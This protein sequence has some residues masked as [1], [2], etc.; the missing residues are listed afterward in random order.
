MGC[1]RCSRS[2]NITRLHDLATRRVLREFRHPGELVSWARLSRDGQRLVTIGQ[3]GSASCLEH[4]RGTS[5]SHQC[6][7]RRAAGISRHG[8]VQSPMAAWCSPREGNE[9]AR[10]WAAD[11]G[12]VLADLLGHSGPVT[13][14]DFHPDGHQVA[15][16]SRDNTLRISGDSSRGI[17]QGSSWPR[18]REVIE[19]QS[20][21]SLDCCLG[22][23]R[24]NRLECPKPGNCSTLFP[25]RPRSFARGSAPMANAWQRALSTERHVWEVKTGEPLIE[26][27]RH[28]AY[29]N[30]IQFSTDG[31]KLV[32]TSADNVARVWDT[33]PAH[34]LCIAL[35]NRLRQPVPWANYFT[36]F[37]PDANRVVAGGGPEALV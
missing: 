13:S 22:R 2:T 20:R 23:Q 29:V 24:S 9:T 36:S 4:G 1:L 19:L 6:L 34:V 11:T 37:S 26:V 18:R 25:I 17:E 3:S 33:E 28:G 12:A 31:L 16:V 5:H 7:S 30:S 35:W 27:L 14:G 21:R 8:S 10:L 32:T 15:T